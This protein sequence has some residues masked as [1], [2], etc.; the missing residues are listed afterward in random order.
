ML[1][2]SEV[3]R[4]S[5][6][7]EGTALQKLLDPQRANRVIATYTSAA[8][9]DGE[10]TPDIASLLKP[11]LTRYEK[12]FATRP[13]DY[14]AEYLDALNWGVLILL[15]SSA[16]IKEQAAQ[17]TTSSKAPSFD[18]KEMGEALNRLMVV[19]RDL[20]AKSINQKIDAGVFSTAGAKR[21]LDYAQLLTSALEKEAP[22][23]EWR[24]RAVASG[25]I[26][27]NN[28]CAACHASG[29]VGAPRFRDTDAWSPR[30]RSGLANL[31]A[32]ALNGKGVM[33]PQRGGDYLDFE[34]ARAVVYMANAAGGRFHEP[35][36]P[37]G[38]ATSIKYQVSIKPIETRSS[39]VPYAA[40]DFDAKL[41][42]GEKVYAS[43]CVVCHQRSG[44]GAGP[45]P[46]LLKAKSLE[47][48]ESAISVLL[49]GGGN[50]TM[51][52]WKN[53]RD[54]EIA[55][56]INYMRSTFGAY[57]LTPVTPEAVR[58]RR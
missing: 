19:V 43:N 15:Q 9:T 4:Y 5:D 57:M 50:G 1:R 39:E 46:S 25:E 53:L 18:R 34:I 2:P 52:S 26:V 16:S 7:E 47:S 10:A 37:P 35:A 54:D 28:Q 3:L 30:I 49:N 55:T 58:V 42:F 22:R 48:N 11:L 23:F 21:A 8:V 45:I 20:L 29:A 12:A 27:Y 24:T 32:S 13:Q 33:A 36:I 40:M 41:K 6:G 31:L 17:N 14:E 51:P 56:V 38:Q 44:K